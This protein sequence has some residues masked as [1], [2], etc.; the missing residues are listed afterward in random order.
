MCMIKASLAGNMLDL[1][2]Q[3]QESS[4]PQKPGPCRQLGQTVWKSSQQEVVS[5]L[6]VSWKGVHLY[7]E[8]LLPLM[9]LCA[10]A[11]PLCPSQC[12]HCHQM[13]LKI[14][15]N[16]NVKLLPDAK[17]CMCSLSP[18][19]SKAGMALTLAFGDI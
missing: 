12:I 15:N 17:P 9:Q 14:V 6:C 19:C 18:N 16:H 2:P 1:G 8:T 10:L 7:Q 3:M 13:P 5:G 4:S 11:F